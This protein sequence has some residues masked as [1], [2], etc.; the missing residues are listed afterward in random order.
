MTQPYNTN[1]ECE[2]Q[3][4]QKMFNKE[5]F[6]RFYSNES[7]KTST[8][9]SKLGYIPLDRAQHFNDLTKK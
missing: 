6:F 4:V 5:I 8:Q 7:R 3:H 1:K 2:K 9:P